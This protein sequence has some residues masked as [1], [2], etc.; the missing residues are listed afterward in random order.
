MQT[1]PFAARSGPAAQIPPPRPVCSGQQIG[2]LS[3][4]PQEISSLP[5]MTWETALTTQPHARPG[6]VGLS[7]TLSGILPEMGRG[8]EG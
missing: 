7:N 2:F 1:Q 4:A 5:G 6:E 3:C 8:A